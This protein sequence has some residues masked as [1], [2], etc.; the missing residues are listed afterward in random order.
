MTQKPPCPDN[1]VEMTCQ[2]SR[3]RAISKLLINEE[4]LRMEGVK[5]RNF[6]I[7]TAALTLSAC[8]GGPS[9]PTAPGSSGATASPTPAPT[10]PAPTP[11]TP[12]PVKAAHPSLLHTQ[13]DFDRMAAKVA[14]KASPWI[15]SWNILTGP[16]NNP[17]TFISLNRTP[18]AQVVIYRGF[19][20]VHAQNY[21]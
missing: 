6:L 1:F 8:G 14:A 19:D 7:A 11:P 3:Y 10:G 18:N 17:N 20:G 15:D 13:A 4:D 12:G 9:S 16:S 2:P 21:A 5:R